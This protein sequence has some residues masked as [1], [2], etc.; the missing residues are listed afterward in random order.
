MNCLSRRAEI[1]V[2]ATPALPAPTFPALPVPALP[3]PPVTEHVAVL[4]VAGKAAGIVGT[5]ELGPTVPTMGKT[6]VVGTAGAELTPRLLI[7][8]ESNGIPVR[9]APPGVVGNVDVDVGADD[10]AMLLEPEPHIPDIPDVSIPKVDVPIGTDICD[11]VDVPGVAVGS[12]D[13]AVG[14]VSVMPDVAMPPVV[15]AVAGA[16]MPADVPPPSKLAVDPNIPDGNIPPVEHVVPLVV[17]APLVGIAIVP[18]TLPVGAGL[19]PGDVISVAPIGI[20]VPPTDPSG[21]IPSGEVTPSEGVAVSG[22][23][24]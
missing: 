3:M 23:S 20:P 10:E 2:P 19:T 22:S 16:A 9:A 1:D 24:T 8:V 4:A 13:A 18:V 14:S 7:S 15:A 11:D 5:D 17:I 6:P 12:V 21:P